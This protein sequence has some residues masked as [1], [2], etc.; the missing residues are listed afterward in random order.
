MKAMPVTTILILSFLNSRQS[1][2]QYAFSSGGRF[3]NSSSSGNFIMIKGYRLSDCHAWFG[4][5]FSTTH[6]LGEN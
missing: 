5:A 2:N 3:L 6:V 4:S 1:C